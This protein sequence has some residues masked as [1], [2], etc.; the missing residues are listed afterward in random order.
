[1]NKQENLTKPNQ[2]ETEEGFPIQLILLLIVITGAVIGIFLKLIG[3][4]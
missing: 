4:I 3:I 1:M 2:Q